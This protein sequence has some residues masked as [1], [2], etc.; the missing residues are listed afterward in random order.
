MWGVH[1]A[2]DAEITP[3]KREDAGD[4][5][6]FGNSSDRSINIVN[7]RIHIL[8]QQVSRA[9]NVQSSKGTKTYFVLGN[10]LRKLEVAGLPPVR[11]RK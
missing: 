11:V 2:D 4:I 10:C 3:V 6:S 8:S 7:T 1:G 5:Q 9:V